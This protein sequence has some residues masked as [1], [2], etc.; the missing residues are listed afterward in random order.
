MTPTARNSRLGDVLLPSADVTQAAVRMFN[1]A[2]PDMRQG[3]IYEFRRLYFIC[4]HQNG[5]KAHAELYAQ[6]I[7]ALGADVR[8]N[9]VKET[10]A[11]NRGQQ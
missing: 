9:T 10:Q 3:V 11:F 1:A 6:A 7:H 8:F 5:L 2:P 4:R